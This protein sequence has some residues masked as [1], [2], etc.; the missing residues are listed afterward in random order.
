[1][2]F[3]VLEPYSFHSAKDWA[4]AILP[5]CFTKVHTIGIDLIQETFF[6]KKPVDSFP[7]P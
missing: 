2:E 4:A 1:M 7:K 5:T 6:T 3:K